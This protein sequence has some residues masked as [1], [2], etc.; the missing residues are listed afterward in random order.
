[1]YWVRTP[2]LAPSES[3][4]SNNNKEDK[5]EDDEDEE[6]AAARIVKT[7]DPKFSLPTLL[8]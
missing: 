8:R 2:P 5:G 6:S 4:P 1:M 3:R 7:K